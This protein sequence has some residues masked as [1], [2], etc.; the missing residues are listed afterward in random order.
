MGL[1]NYEKESV[2]LFNE[3][4]KTA[5]F[6]TYNGS[7]QRRLGELCGQYPGQV[8]LVD[9]NGAGGLTFELPKK[10]LKVSPPRALSPAQKEALEEMNRKR[11]GKCGSK[12]AILEGGDLW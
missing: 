10:W 5:S 2:A 8:R 6:F 3:E 1:S 7:W 9:D 4:E 12:Q 11:W